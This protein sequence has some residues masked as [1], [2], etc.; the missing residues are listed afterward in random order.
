MAYD[1]NTS[2]IRTYPVCISKELYDKIPDAD[3]RKKIF[4]WMG[5]CMVTAKLMVNY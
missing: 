4:S 2:I 1:A 3:I 5:N